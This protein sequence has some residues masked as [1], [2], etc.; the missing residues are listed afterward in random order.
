MK[1]IIARPFLK[2][3][4]G[5][6][7]L[8]EQIENNLPIELKQGKIKRYVE[9]FVGGGAVFFY[10]IEKYDFEQVLL[11]DINEEVILTYSIIKNQIDELITNLKNIEEE[12]FNLELEEQGEYY[13]NKRKLF[14]EQKK[15]LNYIEIIQNENF[16]EESI[17]HAS[18]MIFLNKTCFN[19]LYRQNRK[20]EFNVPFGKR[21]KPTICDINNLQAVNKVLQKNVLLKCGDY[22]DTQDF[23]DG[24]TF[25]YMDPPYRPLSK[26][27]GFIDYSK[28][29]FNEE[30]Q[31]ELSKWFYF[32]NES[33]RAKLML[34]NS[35]P[36][37]TCKGDTFFIDNYSAFKENIK[38]V[39]AVRNINSKGNGRGAITELLITNY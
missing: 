32:L 36:D 7:Q 31:I 38:K 1:N 37:N 14:N 21:K 4:G 22:K 27:S 29:P 25:V 20:G 35:D 8:L 12:Y 24:D 13:Y 39:K 17:L 16:S 18:I 15:V 26:T 34:S 3:A 23:I 10:L 5:K 28:E 2:W 11:N 6:T 30:C 33:K 19:G 9:P